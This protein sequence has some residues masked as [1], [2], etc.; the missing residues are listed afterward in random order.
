MR[1][2]RFI[3]LA[4][5]TIG[6]NAVPAGALT[7]Q[8]RAG[9]AR[10]VAAPVPAPAVPKG[11]FERSVAGIR[12][13]IAQDQADPTLIPQAVP[14]LYDHG[15][16]VR[17]AVILFHGFTN[18]PQQFDVLARGFF[19]RGCNV[20]VPRIPY[21]G[22]KDRL[23]WDLAN[24]TVPI[25]Q[26]FG[27][28]TYR[29]ANGLGERV[30]AL[31]LSLGGSLALWL[32]QT[33]PIALSVPVSPF[34]MPIGFARGIGTFAMHVLHT[35]P[36]M[37]WW[38]DPRLKAKCLPTYAYPGYPTH[39][40]AQCVFLGSA[41]FDQVPRKPSTSR[42]TLVTNVNEPAVNNNVTYELMDD[43]KSEGITYSHF[44]F[45][46]LGPPRHDIIDPT[47]FP[48]ARTL[49]Y[50]KLESLVLQDA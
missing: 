30:T 7:A 26:E 42:C 18:C 16:P 35:L 50:P 14:R 2:A 22:K 29:L 4:A 34:L 25:L 5:G 27:A 3:A 41:L 43:W 48:Q 20:Y 28:E 15:K 23:T 1:R 32:G 31:G 24:L 46:D 44:V 6:A 49:V 36:D 39:A 38:W 12:A 45:T 40:L 19:A 47:T 21:H 33:Q 9:N 10:K 13:V 17:D 37:Y 8:P 11:T